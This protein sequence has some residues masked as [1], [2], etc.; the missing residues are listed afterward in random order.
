LP[1][2]VAGSAFG[3]RLQATLAIRN[4]V[5]RRDTVELC[6]E[7]FG[8]RISTGSADAILT[9]AADALELPYLD[10]TRMLRRAGHLNVDETGWRLRCAQRTLWGAFS[11]KLAVAW[12]GVVLPSVYQSAQGTELWN[13][14]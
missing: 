10:L 13:G 6:A 3:P 1:G 5:S 7:L 12:R 8:A 14:G 2:E 4:R 11:A 9:T